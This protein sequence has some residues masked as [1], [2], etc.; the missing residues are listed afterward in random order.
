MKHFKYAVNTI[1]YKYAS[2]CFSFFF[3]FPSVFLSKM[4]STYFFF[5]WTDSIYSTYSPLSSHCYCCPLLILSPQTLKF[6]KPNSPLFS[7]ISSNWLLCKREREK[8]SWI[9]SRKEGRDRKK[10]RQKDKERERGKERGKEIEKERGRERRGGKKER[11]KERNCHKW[12]K[13]KKEENQGP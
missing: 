5:I 11:E 1:I 2:F 9:D 13:R 7:K 10:E 6:L 4:L 3:F 8:E 12:A